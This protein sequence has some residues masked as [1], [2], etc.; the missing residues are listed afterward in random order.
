[1]AAAI[2]ILHLEPCLEP[3]KLDT[4]L[5]KMESADAKARSTK[6][7]ISD[8]KEPPVPT[9]LEPVTFSWSNITADDN[10]KFWQALQTPYALSAAYEA[11]TAIIQCATESAPYK[12]VKQGGVNQSTTP[13]MPEEKSRKQE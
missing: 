2:G 11:N 12:T 5:K 1:M 9:Y 10:F 4:L 13:H 3:K 8:V 6:T 7:L